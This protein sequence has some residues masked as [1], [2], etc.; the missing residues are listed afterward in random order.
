MKLS[1]PNLLQI[2]AVKVAVMTPD[3][4][5]RL[6]VLTEQRPPVSLEDVL[7]DCDNL[8]EDRAID[9]LTQCLSGL[10]VIHTANLVHRGLEPKCVNLAP[11]TG[12]S[13]GSGKLV[14]LGRVSYHTRLLDL[15]RSN[16]FWTSSAAPVGS[17]SPT[18]P[19]GWSVYYIFCDT[20]CLYSIQ[21]VERCSRKPAFV[22]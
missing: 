18:I 14:K 6:V 8:R 12:D 7:E 10:N 1:H 11:R 17:A 2:L 22:Y 19:E 3:E 13:G 21:A 9:Y 5:L 16:P 4:P 15:H 20:L